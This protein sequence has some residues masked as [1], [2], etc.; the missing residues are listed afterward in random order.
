[1]LRLLTLAILVLGL[2]GSAPA[3]TPGTLRVSIAL[4]DADGR[5]T[6]A[7]RHPLLVSDDPP[8]AEPRR[9]ITGLDGTVAVSLRPG[10]YTVES[11]RPLAFRGRRYLW[12]QTIDIAAGREIVL[13]LTSANAEPDTGASTATDADATSDPGFLLRDW[14]GSVFA[15]WT[16]TTHASGF[17]VDARGLVVTLQRGI[18]VATTAEVQLT[19]ALK[20]AGRVLAADAERDV[21]VLWI[22][23]KVAATA[24]PVPLACATP[25]TPPGVGD[26]LY[27]IGVPLRGETDM[28]SAG[29]RAVTPPAIDADFLLPAG[30]AGGPVFTAGGAL[31]GMTSWAPASAEGRD[32]DARVIRDRDVCTVLAAAAAAIERTEPPS[33]TLLPVEPTAAFPIDALTGALERPAGS[34]KPY[35]ISSADFDLTLLTPTVVY[36]ELNASTANR[37]TTSKETRDPKAD[38]SFMRPRMEFGRWADYVADVQPV[39]LVRITPRFA[40]GFWAKVGR[41]AAETQGVML[42]P[43]KRFKSGFVRLR[44]LCGASE[45][46]PIHPFELDTNVS[47]TATIDEGLYVF[48]PDALGPHCGTVTFELYSVTGGAKADTRVLDPK[49]LEQIWQDFEPFR[50]AKD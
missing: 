15:V 41:V 27:A 36:A 43:R 8:T 46:L 2:A 12:R 9:I 31:V 45:M 33:A 13:D 3:Q 20:V 30:T 26:R 39:L 18:G 23:A 34:V 17:L 40:E 5:V 1:M 10:S 16:A 14:Q 42:P 24:R 47:E 50:A 28:T 11:D 21:A 4:A 32:R 19:P 25:A 38:L 7:P 6:P 29:V 37:R 49:I 35:V 44:A 48:D 22:D